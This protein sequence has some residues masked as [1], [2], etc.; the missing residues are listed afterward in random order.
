[1][2]K[3]TIDCMVTRCTNLMQKQNA[4]SLTEAVQS[5]GTRFFIFT[6]KYN[7]QSTTLKLTYY[8]M[9]AIAMTNNTKT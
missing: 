6:H 5:R 9:S 3:N 4:H 1:M 2:T 7:V 8:V